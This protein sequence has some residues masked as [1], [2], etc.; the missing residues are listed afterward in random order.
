[1][2]HERDR[3][4]VVGAGPNVAALLDAPRHLVF[5]VREVLTG[6]GGGAGA[7]LP[8]DR[9]AGRC[10]GAERRRQHHVETVVVG[11]EPEYLEERERG[12]FDR[13]TPGHT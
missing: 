3:A 12:V 2:A 5:P 11:L 10:R 9:H 8:L 4:A 1:M 7:G 13:S 6:E